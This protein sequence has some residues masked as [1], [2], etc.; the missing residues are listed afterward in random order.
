M[1]TNKSTKQASSAVKSADS[2]IGHSSRVGSGTKKVISEEVQEVFLTPEEMLTMD[3]FVMQGE[4]DAA[5]SQIVEGHVREKQ[6]QIRIQ[7]LEL[8]LHQIKL[9][10]L[11][12]QANENKAKSLDFVQR[13]KNQ[14]QIPKDKWGYDPDTGKVTFE[15]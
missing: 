2:R 1:T 12:H 5:L 13:I 10:K 11:R 6:Q 14:Y 8:E 3:K 15:N 9:G 7:Q 4:I